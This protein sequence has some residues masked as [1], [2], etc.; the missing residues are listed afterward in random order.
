MIKTS[1]KNSRSY[2]E[3]YVGR[4]GKRPNGSKVMIKRRVGRYCSREWILLWD[5]NTLA[6]LTMSRKERDRGT[7]AQ[8]AFRLLSARSRAEQK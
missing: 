6:V 1:S 3:G 7:L 4:L 8:A 5:E 2:Y